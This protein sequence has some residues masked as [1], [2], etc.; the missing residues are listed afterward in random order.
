MGVP[1]YDRENDPSP[2]VYTVEIKGEKYRVRHFPND[3]AERPCC[4]V[5]VQMIAADREYE[6][7]AEIATLKRAY[8]KIEA[9][10]GS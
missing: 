6:H 3:R 7:G 10:H 2:D 9:K 4:E 8:L 5:V 1:G